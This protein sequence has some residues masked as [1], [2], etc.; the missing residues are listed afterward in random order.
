MRTSNFARFSHQKVMRI[1]TLATLE[2][3]RKRRRERLHTA[4]CC[5]L[6][7]GLCVLFAY[8]AYGFVI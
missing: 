2:E 1:R 8:V 3:D 6:W 4:M 7:F 5:G